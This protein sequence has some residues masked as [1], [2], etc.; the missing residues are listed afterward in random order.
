MSIR[1]RHHGEKLYTCSHSQKQ[2]NSSRNLLDHN[3]EFDEVLVSKSTV[4]AEAIQSPP[5]ARARFHVFFDGCLENQE[6]LV[7][8]VKGEIEKNVKLSLWRTSPV[9]DARRCQGPIGEAG[10]LVC[11]KIGHDSFKKSHVLNRP[12]QGT[13]ERGIGVYRRYTDSVSDTIRTSNEDNFFG[14]KSTT[15]ENQRFLGSLKILNRVTYREVLQS[16]WH[17]HFQS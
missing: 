1:T 16:T 7:W 10:S 15:C 3:D 12:R 8:G 5:F 4:H 14:M 9:D 11:R 6:L 13:V 2:L 17:L